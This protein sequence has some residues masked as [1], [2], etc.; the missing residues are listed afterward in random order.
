MARIV[1]LRLPVYLTGFD[2][3]GGGVT[4]HTLDGTTDALE[5][6]FQAQEAITIVDLGFAYGNRTG[7]CPA[8]RISLQGVTA[9]GR[10]DGTIKSSANAFVNFT[11]PATTAWDDTFRWQTLGASYTCTRGEFLAIVISYSSGTINASN[12]S[13]FGYTQASSRGNQW[14]FPITVE[15]GVGT[16]RQAS[17]IYAYRSSSSTY[18]APYQGHTMGN[19]SSDSS[20]DER[21]LRFVIPVDICSTYTLA[22]VDL[23]IGNPAANKSFKIIL[24]TGTTVLQTLTVDSDQNQSVSSNNWSEFYFQETTLSNLTAGSVYYLGFQPQET[25]NN[26]GITRQ[27]VSTNTDFDAWPLGRTTYAAIRTDAGAWTDVLTDRL[28]VSLI[29]GSFTQAGG[30]TIINMFE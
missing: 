29:F 14:P 2:F 21:A 4:K 19:F 6:V 10:A 26:L 28:V 30:S 18:G 20:P 27:T 12:C 23:N 11:P 22:G 7:T 17:P 25:S 24:Y 3:T 16:R 5:F 15:A 13:S 1:P 8:Y 9:L